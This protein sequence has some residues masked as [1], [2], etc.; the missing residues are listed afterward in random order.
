MKT[1]RAKTITDDASD[2]LRLTSDATMIH[3]SLDRGG[4]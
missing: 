1:R 4:T 3:L 2:Q